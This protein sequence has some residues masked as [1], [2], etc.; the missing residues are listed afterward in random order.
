[1]DIF[2]SEEFLRRFLESRRLS[3]QNPVAIGRDETCGHLWPRTRF[4]QLEALSI[5]GYAEM[6]SFFLRNPPVYIYIYYNIHAARLDYSGVLI[7]ALNDLS[8]YQ[9]AVTSGPL[10]RGRQ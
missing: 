5:H 3:W 8:S 6:P 10:L 2:L 4:S 1:M 9:S 7:A